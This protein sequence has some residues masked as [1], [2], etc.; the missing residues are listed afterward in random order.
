MLKYSAIGWITSEGTGLGVGIK[1]EITDIYILSVSAL[2]NKL[3]LGGA[4][5]YLCQLKPEIFL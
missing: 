3:H 5:L 1:L 4:S 2:D